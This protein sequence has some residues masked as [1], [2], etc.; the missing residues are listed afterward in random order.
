MRLLPAN[1][2]GRVGGDAD[3]AP[4]VMSDLKVERR[5]IRLHW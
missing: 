2:S 5:L 3:T 1:L 4:G